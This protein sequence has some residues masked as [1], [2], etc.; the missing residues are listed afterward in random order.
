MESVAKFK[1]QGR[2]VPDLITVLHESDAV[3]MNMGYFQYTG[4]PQ[5]T[6]LH[7]NCG[8]M[9]AGAAWQEAWHANSGI[10]VMA[11]RTPW[12]TK[13]ERPGSRS[14]YVHWQQEMYDQAEMIRQF[15][16]WDYEI[17]TVE[18]A[19]L[20]VQSAFRIAATEPCGPVYITLRANNGC[21]NAQRHRY[22]PKIFLQRCHH[23][24]SAAR[25]KRKILVSARNG[26][27][28][29]RWTPSGGCRSCGT[30]E[31]SQSRCLQPTYMNF[32]AA[33]GASRAIYGARCHSGIDHDV[34]GTCRPRTS[35]IISMDRSNTDSRYELSSPCNRAIPPNHSI[36]LQMAVNL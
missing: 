11:G 20:V 8:T 5:V 21:Q 16:K 7:V 10:V 12:T 24:H 13:N 19:S 25:V 35:R 36:L 2:P 23:R 28:R 29:Q 15:L 18:N 17:R 26:D 27:S 1:S 34:P 32:Q 33:L 4:Q 9:N 14:V 3:Y 30:S 22:G 31:N 6:V